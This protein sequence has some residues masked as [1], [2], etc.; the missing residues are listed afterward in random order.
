MPCLTSD[1]L[2]VHAQLLRDDLCHLN[3]ALGLGGAEDYRARCRDLWADARSRCTLGFC[4]LHH[5]STRMQNSGFYFLDPGIW[6][7][8]EELCQGEH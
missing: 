6:I 7:A 5:R 2:L 4:N 3:A 8:G 1:L